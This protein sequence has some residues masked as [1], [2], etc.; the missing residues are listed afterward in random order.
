[1]SAVSNPEI[2]RVQAVSAVQ[3]PEILRVL[4]VYTPEVCQYSEY[5]SCLPERNL[6]QL[7]LVRISVQ[8]LRQERGMKL[9]KRCTDG[10]KYE[11]YFVLKSFSEYIYTAHVQSAF[12]LRVLAVRAVASGEILPVLV[13]AIPA[14]QN[15]DILGSTGI[16]HNSIKVSNLKT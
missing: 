15:P 5:S 9:S 11:I 6:L 3:N 14:V 7:L 2:L 8:V 10:S 4:A 16:I 12:V 13:L 1:M